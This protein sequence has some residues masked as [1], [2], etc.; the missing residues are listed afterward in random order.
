MNVSSRVLK[1][2]L[3]AAWAVTGGLPVT[4]PAT[5]PPLRP[6]LQLQA[7]Q[8]TALLSAG[9]I[10]SN[11]SNGHTTEFAGALDSE[12]VVQIW[13]YLADLFDIATT[14][15]QSATP[16]VSTPTDTQVKAQMEFNLRP[17]YGAT[18]NYMWL[19]K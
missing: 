9:Q 15:L 4:F 2:H 17:I 1:A 18:G 7:S 5:P 6:Y 13:V 3:W 14:E 16:P 8:S 12:Q 10:K 19:I 11:V